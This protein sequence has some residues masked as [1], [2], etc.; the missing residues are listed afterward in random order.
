LEPK[1]IRERNR[2]I[3]EYWKVGR[4]GGI[5]EEGK[6]EFLNEC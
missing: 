5:R 3:M 6:I 4:L 2:G 1:D